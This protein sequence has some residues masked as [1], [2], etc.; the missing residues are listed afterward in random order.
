MRRARAG[1]GKSTLAAR[2]AARYGTHRAVVVPADG[3]H[4]ARATRSSSSRAW[5][6]LL[7]IEPWSLIA[8]EMD[9]TVRIDIP[10]DVAAE[11]LAARHLACGLA[12]TRELAM[13]RATE[14]D[15]VNARLILDHPIAPD[16]ALPYD[17]LIGI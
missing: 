7:D 4:L 6:L 2:I 5:Y 16:L 13:R 14:N 17:V 3:W 10:L 11:R 12:A 8:A 9:F 1:A 15:L